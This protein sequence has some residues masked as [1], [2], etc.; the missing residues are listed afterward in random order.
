MNDL[1]AKPGTD[2]TFVRD[3]YWKITAPAGDHVA[4]N[5]GGGIAYVNAKGQPVMKLTPNDVIDGSG[6]RH[7]VSWTL[8]G[9]TVYQHIDIKGASVKGHLAPAIETYGFWGWVTC[10][11]KASKGYAVGGAVGGC[12]ADIETGCAPGAVTGVGVGAIAGAASGLS[13]C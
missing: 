3:T 1:L 13:T 11:G 8:K 10:V 5:P 2:T 9:D 4:S 12:V 7:K 6:A